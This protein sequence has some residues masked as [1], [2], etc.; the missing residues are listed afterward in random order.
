[1]PR[2]TTV[3]IVNALE[4][5]MMRMKQKRPL[6]KKN[7]NFKNL[8]IKKNKKKSA[9][10]FFNFSKLPPKMCPG[11]RRLH[12]QRPQ[13]VNEEDEA[14]EATESSSSSLG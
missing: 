9:N 8:K 11:G 7:K 4:V 14:E 13:S 12:P 2:G 10:F 1:M 3:Y 6:E 5:F